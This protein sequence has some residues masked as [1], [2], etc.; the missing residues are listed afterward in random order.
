[1]LAGGV[2]PAKA[3]SIGGIVLAKVEAVLA[4]VVRR[5]AKAMTVA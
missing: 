3:E 5:C 2:A 1:M 4:D